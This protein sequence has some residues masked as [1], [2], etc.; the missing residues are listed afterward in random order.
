MKFTKELNLLLKARY[1]ILYISSFE[2]ERVEYLIFKKIRENTDRLIYSWNFI[3]GY[4]NYLQNPKFAAKNPLQALELIENL[5]IDRGTIFILKD[6]HKFLFDISISRKIK[7]LLK[8]LRTQS[9]TIIILSSEIEIPKE[10]KDSITNL[11]FLL[12]SPN[13]IKAEL[14][15]LEN[16]LEKKF[17]LEFL[18]ILIRS[19]QSF[20]IEKIRR[21]LTK[22]IAKYGVIN[23]KTIKLIYNEKK[24]LINETKILEFCQPKQN[25]QDIGGNENLK[26]WLKYRKEAF[27]NKA[28][29]YGLPSP[30]GLLLIGI[31]GTGKSLTAKAIAN[32]WNVPLLKLDVGKIFAG[33]IGESESRI[34]EM[35]K[36]SEALEPCILWIDEI[37][38]GFNEQIKVGD[39]GTTTR[40]FA[41]FIS[42]LSEKTSDVF[43]IATA[44][45]FY[46]LPLE[47][48]RKGRFDE[49]FFIGLPNKNER[50][51]IF[52]VI[53]ERFRK[54][55]EKLFNFNHLSDKSVGFSG[56]EIEQAIIEG[57]YI[58]FNEKREFTETDIVSGL[59]S[60]IPLSKTHP[61]KLVE[62]QN[63]A[64]SGKIR[65][66][67]QIEKK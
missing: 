65:I 17:D 61:D 23:Y 30:R 40:V 10:L 60:I 52:E 41:T 55:N 45:D 51:K 47:L 43:I 36:L 4:K 38:K 46:S 31:Q 5:K 3:D 27:S 44:N 14:L 11:E 8:I 21:I 64:L 19:F 49:I 50:K 34:R 13:Q 58:A 67:S 7:N 12:P 16:I 42:W 57:M 62:N 66:A 33:I 24:I 25:F 15:R 6:F 18:E 48:I 54:Y 35:I 59:N 22:S 63:L 37:D 32:E 1:P 26:N 39:G 53:I 29:L 56:A 9:K 20:S 28:K 2:E